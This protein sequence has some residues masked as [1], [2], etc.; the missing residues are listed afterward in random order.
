MAALF[1][2]EIA[3]YALL[4]LPILWLLLRHGPAGLLGWLYLFIFC[5]LRIVGGVLV[6]KGK[7]AGDIVASVGI[8]PLLLAIDG[9]LHEARTYRKAVNSGNNLEWI[10]VGIFHVLVTSGI[11]LVAVGASNLESAHPSSND[12][13]LVK[14]GMGVLEACWVI[15]ALWAVSSLFSKSRN[16]LAYKEGTTLLY[17]VFLALPLAEIR[18]VYSLVAE[19]TQKADLNPV[20][21]SL[22]VRV[23]LSFLPEL[24]ITLIFVVA[25]AVTRNVPDP[26]DSKRRNQAVVVI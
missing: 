5:G 26:R 12:F 8:S 13:T 7:P 19:C 23:V 11:A 9:I 2:T 14:A 1:D 4:A 10:F 21:G 20:T 15:L 6:I 22:A 16:A 25:G 18:V 3:I 17:S 24:F